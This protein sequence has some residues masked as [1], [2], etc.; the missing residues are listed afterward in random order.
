[1]VGVVEGNKGIGFGFSLA[2][3]GNHDGTR[4][5]VYVVSAVS[6]TTVVFLSDVRPLSLHSTPPVQHVM[7]PCI[8]PA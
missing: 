3:D 4:F 1:M 2:A 7:S 8:F 6:L 5:V